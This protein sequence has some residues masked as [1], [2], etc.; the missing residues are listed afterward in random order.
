VSLVPVTIRGEGALADWHRRVLGRHRDC[1]VLVGELPGRD[2]MVDCCGPVDAC[3]EAIGACVRGRIP[4]VLTNPTQWSD[5]DLQRL[6]GA[7]RKRKLPVVALGSLRLLPA[8]ACLKEIVSTG[9]LGTLRSVSLTR[10][11]TDEAL[12]GDIPDPELTLWRDADLYH[13]LAGGEVPCEYGTIDDADGERTERTF[14]LIGELG[15]VFAR[16]RIGETPEVRITIG[17]TT[18]NRRVPMLSAEDLHLAELQ[19]L[20]AARRDGYP[21]LLLPTLADVVDARQAER[22][23]R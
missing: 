10:D 12:A 14:E 13:W 5:D 20:V 19:V 8:V 9:V 15:T 11:G 3:T 23:G 4:L 16:F 21:W 22:F 17:D 1:D 18:R 6:H 7:S 2:G